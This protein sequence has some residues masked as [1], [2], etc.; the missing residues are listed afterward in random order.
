MK[1]FAQF[2]PSR[3]MLVG[4]RGGE[5]RGLVMNRRASGVAS[6]LYEVAFKRVGTDALRRLSLPQ[7]LVWR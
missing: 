7:R 4:R 1:A 2:K 3:Q 6:A 5:G